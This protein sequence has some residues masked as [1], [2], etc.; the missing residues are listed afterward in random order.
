VVP[1]AGR[2]STNRGS[3]LPG[4]IHSGI[5]D[6]LPKDFFPLTLEPTLDSVWNV[7]YTSQT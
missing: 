4:V 3:T 2:P 5:I 1:H 7:P 6:R